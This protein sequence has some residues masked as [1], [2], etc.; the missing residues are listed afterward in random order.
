MDESIFDEIP[1]PNPYI[2]NG[3]VAKTSAPENTL[4][5]PTGNSSFVY[6]TLQHAPEYVGG[7]GGTFY[8]IDSTNFPISKTIAATFVTLKPG[9]LRELHWHPNVGRGVGT[10]RSYEANEYRPRN[11]YI[12]TEGKLKQRFLSEMALH[13]RST[14]APETRQFSPI[15]QGM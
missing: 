2:P 1:S 10:L 5:V 6:R 9:A 3:T 14:L 13:A 11:G 12:F 4:K 15:T 7:T 8:K